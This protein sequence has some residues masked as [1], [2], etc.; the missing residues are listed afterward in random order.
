M[1][2]TRNPTIAITVVGYP[3][4]GKSRIAS[5]I[6][7]R[8]RGEYGGGCI[9]DAPEHTTEEFP[10][11]RSGTVFMVREVNPVDEPAQAQKSHSLR[12][13][14][15]PPVEVPAEHQCD[16]KNG[17]PTPLR[18]E[19]IAALYQIRPITVDDLVDKPVPLQIQALLNRLGISCHDPYSE[20]DLQPLIDIVN[21]TLSPRETNVPQTARERES[22]PRQALSSELMSIM[23]PHIE[24]YQ[25]HE[26]VN[27]A[28]IALFS[29]M[30]PQTVVRELRLLIGNTPG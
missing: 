22:T 15:M 18:F 6:A 17:S 29:L 10:H 23:S 3:G 7:D 19:E 11:P 28:V 5:M 30:T 20:T 14:C 12:R 9:I 4:T 16:A 1:T 24:R 8:L 26:V 13:I 25:E 21:W 27:A 2:D